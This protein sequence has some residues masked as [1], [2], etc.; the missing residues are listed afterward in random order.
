MT[1][2]DVSERC[3][4]CGLEQPPLPGPTHRYLTASP[5]CWRAFGALLAVGYA[6]PGRRPFHQVVVDAYAAQH[7]GEGLREQVQSVGLHLTTLCLFLEHGTDPALGPRM[8]RRMIRRPVFHRVEPVGRSPVTVVDVPLGGAPDDARRAAH[9]WGRAV[10]GLY[11]H[12][13]ATV[14][15][16]L[17]DAG[18]DVPDRAGKRAARPMLTA[19]PH[20]SWE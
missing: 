18:F 3:P 12:E 11:A 15:R 16:W 10:W 7:P 19:A 4:G 9:A 14:R 5:A 2:G 1:G 20:P 8:H 6:T 17:D 13:H